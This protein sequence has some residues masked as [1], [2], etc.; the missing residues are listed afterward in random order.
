[1]GV[2]SPKVTKIHDVSIDKEYAQWIDEVKKRYR[3]AQIK[4]S[5]KVNTEQL[6][7]NWQLGR[8]LVIRKA[9]ERWGA[10]VVE[11]ICLDLQAEFPESRGFSTTNLWYMKQWY[12]FYTE[13]GQKLHQLGGE[14]IKS[15]DP[16]LA[17]AGFPALLAL[18]PYQG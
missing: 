7:F 2:E 6:I 4:A 9:E 15:G 13:N 11:H 5:V 16:N 1:M 3:C 18:I 14:I 10:G 17:G 8:D 12:R